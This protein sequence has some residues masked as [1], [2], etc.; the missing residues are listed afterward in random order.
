MNTLVCFAF[1]TAFLSFSSSL[2]IFNSGEG[3]KLKHLSFLDVSNMASLN[4]R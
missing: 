2:N 1:C 3:T 4:T